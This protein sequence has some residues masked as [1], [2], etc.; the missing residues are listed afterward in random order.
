MTG[1]LR[2]YCSTRCRKAAHR[3]RRQGKL[4]PTDPRPGCDVDGCTAAALVEVDAARAESRLRYC[5]GHARLVLVATQGRKR[6]RRL[7]RCARCSRWAPADLHL[8]RAGRTRPL[9]GSCTEVVE[10]IVAAVGEA[11]RP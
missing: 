9:C 7:E 5:E 4:P 8:Q 10:E 2:R 3:S 6:L 11:V 1:R